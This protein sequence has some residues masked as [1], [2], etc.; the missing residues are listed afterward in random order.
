MLMI[1]M[2]LVNL[3]NKIQEQVES[4]K[5]KE[6]KVSISID[7]Q[8]DADDIARAIHNAIDSLLDSWLNKPGHVSSDVDA[9]PVQVRVC[10]GGKCASTAIFVDVNLSDDEIERL[11]N[12]FARLINVLAPSLRPT[13]QDDLP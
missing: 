10:V 2:G 13:A 3:Y 8:Y 5:L 1:N 11:V 6:V 9:R 12:A 4:G 7:S